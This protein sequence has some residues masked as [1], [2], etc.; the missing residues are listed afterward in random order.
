MRPLPVIVAIMLPFAQ[1]LGED[2]ACDS[3][4]SCIITTFPS[5]DHH[6]LK[7]IPLENEAGE[8]V[9]ERL[10]NDTTIID[11]FHA[12]DQSCYTG[13]IADICAIGEILSENSNLDYIQ[14]GHFQAQDFN[15][16]AI[17]KLVRFE[18]TE[19]SDY[20]ALEK[21]ITVRLSPCQ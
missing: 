6:V 13:R 7:L 12:L 18:Y 14:G 8:I 5:G 20:S 3:Q 4:E 9:G 11:N 16:Y 19:L 10:N 17:N 1:A 21:E 15:C 2:F